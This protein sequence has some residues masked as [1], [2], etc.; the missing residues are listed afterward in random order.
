MSQLAI[1]NNPLI[2]VVYDDEA[3]HYI[4]KGKGLSKEQLQFIMMRLFG[5][6]GD[7]RTQHA[8]IAEMEPVEKAA[9]PKPLKL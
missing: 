5:A 3:Q 7:K 4:I 9:K 6:E 8:A 2:T 1:I